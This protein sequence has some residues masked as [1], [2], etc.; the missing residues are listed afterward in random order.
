MAIQVIVEV[1][2][3]LLLLQQIELLAPAVQ[4]K[5]GDRTR[6]FRDEGG[7]KILPLDQKRCRGRGREFALLRR[8]TLLQ[9]QLVSVAADRKK[10]HVRTRRVHSDVAVEHARIH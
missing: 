2:V 3:G 5:L 8:I 9:H 1:E 6:L 7:G 4:Y 10:R